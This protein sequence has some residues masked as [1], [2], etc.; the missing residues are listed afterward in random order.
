MKFPENGRFTMF[1]HSSGYICGLNSN[2]R[3][4]I[5]VAYRMVELLF[6]AFINNKCIIDT[7]KVKHNLI[8]LFSFPGDEYKYLSFI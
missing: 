8:V 4:I 7:Y 1:L 2:R 3:S 5:I 6:N